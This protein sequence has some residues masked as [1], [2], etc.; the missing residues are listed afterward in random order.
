MVHIPAYKIENIKDTDG[1][2][3]VFCSSLIQS[4]VD[5]NKLSVSSVIDATLEAKKLLLSK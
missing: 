3:D 4:L 5:Q 1:C 2:G